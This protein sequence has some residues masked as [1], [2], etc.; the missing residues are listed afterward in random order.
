MAFHLVLSDTYSL[1]GVARVDII[2]TESARATGPG[3]YVCD[4][5]YRC[6]ECRAL[7]KCDEWCWCPECT[8]Y[9]TGYR[10]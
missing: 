6:P 5:N 2:A 10:A 9:R 1:V 3:T 7:P 4:D 8:F